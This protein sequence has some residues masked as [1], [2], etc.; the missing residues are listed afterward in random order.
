MAS[1]QDFDCTFA[2]TGWF[3]DRIVWL[4]PETCQPVPGADGR[5]ARRFPAVPAIRRGESP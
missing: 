4:A 5:R 3:G 2:D 1:V